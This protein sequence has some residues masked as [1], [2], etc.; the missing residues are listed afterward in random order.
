MKRRTFLTGLAALFGLQPPACK[1]PITIEGVPIEYE[2]AFQLTEKEVSDLSIM[3]LQ[4]MGQVKAW[5]K[6]G[7]VLVFDYD[8]FPGERRW[9]NGKRN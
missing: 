2:E 1:K 8:P 7:P 4:K 3:S 5:T 6:I 9:F